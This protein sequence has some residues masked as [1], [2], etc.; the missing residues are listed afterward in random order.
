M[1]LAQ[2]VGGGGLYCYGVSGSGLRRLGPAYTLKVKSIEFSEGFDVG[3][4]RKKVIEK[5]C[6]FV[7]QSGRKNGK[8]PN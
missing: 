5:N 1:A 3:C 6:M 4:E 8:F 7:S 2:V